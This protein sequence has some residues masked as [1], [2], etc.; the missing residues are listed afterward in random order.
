MYKPVWENLI[1]FCRTFQCTPLNGNHSDDL[2]GQFTFVSNQGNSVIDYVVVSTDFIDK[3]CMHFEIGSRV[4][5]SHMLLHLSIAKKQIQ[6]EKEKRST[7]SE[8]STKVRWN[9]QKA[10]EYVEKS[11]RKIPK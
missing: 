9:R 10:G 2:D 11:I 1:E 5:S 3:T 7:N 4:E 8:G 6:E